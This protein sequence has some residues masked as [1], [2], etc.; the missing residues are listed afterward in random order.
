[1][2]YAL[3][4]RIFHFPKANLTIT[5]LE[6]LMD[7][8][9]ARKTKREFGQSSNG[10]RFYCPELDVLRFFAFF[11][12]FL[13]H[14]VLFAAKK[15]MP[16]VVALQLGM[17]LFFVLSSYLITE[18]LSKEKLSTGRIHTQAFF[19]RRIL[20]IWPLYFACLAVA[21]LNGWVDKNVHVSAQWLAAFVLLFGNWY[22][23]LFGHISSPWSPLWSINL[24]EQF[25]FLWPFLAKLKKQWLLSASLCTFPIAWIAI[26]VCSPETK[27]PTSTSIWYNSFVQFQF[28][29]VGSLL[30]L[31]LKGQAP[32]WSMA[33]RFGFAA[34]SLS[35]F[36]FTGILFVWAKPSTLLT[37]VGYGVTAVG[38][39]S[40]LFCLLGLPGR[41]IP[42]FLIDLGK[43]SYGLY[44]FHLP[45]QFYVST[46]VWQAFPTS[47]RLQNTLLV[48]AISLLITVAVAK[49]SYKYFEKP[50]LKIKERF[51]FV[52]SREA[53]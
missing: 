34:L 19:M 21:Y 39:A 26:A 38:C 5:C 49:L 28:F 15:W 32:S 44:V 37:A 22:T 9:L 51:E 24:E 47:S 42:K 13:F 11:S 18:L 29:G 30:S 52:R 33:K 35:S 7:T 50:F 45:V 14:S 17:C 53:S 20:R 4:K 6:T 23:V 2:A 25:Y 41:K 16:I 36:L 46:L 31:V 40:L 1:M 8:L 12:V 3:I 10:S 48:I 43:M 27:G